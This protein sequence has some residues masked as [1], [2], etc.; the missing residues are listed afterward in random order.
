[1]SRN[2]LEQV[3]GFGFWRI[4]K[5]T[6]QRRGRAVRNLVAAPRA[7]AAPS[8]TFSSWHYSPAVWTEPAFREQR[9]DMQRCR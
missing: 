9:V 7:V 2:E 4:L 5:E 1:M 6:S 3:R 8:K